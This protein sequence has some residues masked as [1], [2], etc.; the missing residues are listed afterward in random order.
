MQ[1]AVRVGA[2]MSNWQIAIGFSALSLQHLAISPSEFAHRGNRSHF[3]AQPILLPALNAYVR[4][5]R[6]VIKPR[7]TIEH[8]L[9][10]QGC[11]GAR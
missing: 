6:R 7:R 1:R 5:L 8:K 4:P 10:R 2:D 11:R 3:L 9:L